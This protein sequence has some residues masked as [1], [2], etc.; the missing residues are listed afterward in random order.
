MTR[1]EDGRIELSDN[2]S[3]GLAR[4]AGYVSASGSDLAVAL[5]VEASRGVT[6]LNFALGDSAVRPGLHGLHEPH[7]AT[8]PTPWLSGDR[9]GT[10]GQFARAPDVVLDANGNPAYREATV[11]LFED[12]FTPE[13]VQWISD[14]YGNGGPLSREDAMVAVLAHELFHDIDDASLRAIMSRIGG[15]ADPYAVEGEAYRVE[16]LVLAQIQ[17]TQ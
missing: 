2:A 8:G 7:D 4:F 11:T 5:F 6:K 10:T 12:T 1:R 3:P 15:T 17:G 13:A 9:D 14:T 16:R